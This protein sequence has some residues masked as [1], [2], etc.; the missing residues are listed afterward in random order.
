[1]IVELNRIVSLRYT[2]KNNQGEVLE[3]IMA[4]DPVDY[5]HGSGSILPALESGVEGLQAGDIKLIV[6]NDDTADSGESYFIDVVIDNIREATIAE[7][8][9][10]NP[11]QKP[12]DKSCGS[13]CCC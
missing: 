12:M 8:Q 11:E 2:V 10:G 3:D 6:L 1:M 7:L 5:L 4:G 13:G 9:N